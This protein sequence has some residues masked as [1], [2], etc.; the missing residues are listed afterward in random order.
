MCFTPLVSIITAITEFC[1]AGYLFYR[2]KDR[3]LYPLA[4]F[5][6]FLGLYQF[7]EFML[8]TS[9]SQVIWARIGFAVYTFMPM[10]LAHFFF[11]L[12]RK[13]LNL[14][15][16]FIPV[17]FSLLALFYP[18]F[19]SYTSCNML[20]VSVQSLI[21]NENSFLMLIYLLYYIIF[22]TYG[23]YLFSKN[24]KNIHDSKMLESAVVA[25]PLA[26]LLALAYYIWSSV[27]K[28]N[29]FETWITSSVMLVVAMLVLILVSLFLLKRSKKLF[30]EADVLVL[31]TAGIVV[32]MLYYI[33]PDITLNYSSIFCH[34]AILYAIA[35]VLLIHA[36]DGKIPNR[37][38]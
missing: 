29:Q 36:L 23:L 35:S 14:Y 8:C 16:Y 33:L 26:V 4:F 9:S 2:I 30:Y 21:F 20:S 27:Y 19:I 1:I 28:N 6:L 32:F 13:K 3:K 15:T 7:T 10:L 11:N 37:Q 38:T 25:T 18:G 34:F 5:V 24:I 22:P 12:C 31:S 17:F